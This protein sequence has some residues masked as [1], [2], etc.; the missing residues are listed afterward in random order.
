MTETSLKVLNGILDQQNYRLILYND[1]FNILFISV[2]L[3]LI[4]TLIY[5]KLFS[6][7]KKILS[8]EMFKNVGSSGI[9]LTEIT[10]LFGVV[11]FEDDNGNNK[12]ITCYSY[13][14]KIEKGKRI[15]ITDYDSNKE[16]YIV[17]E[18]PSLG[19]RN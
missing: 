6:N 11:Q 8:N 17:E 19:L 1:M 14:E 7:N 2:I 15:L 18:Y 3:T 10:L 4:I 13:N 5:Y 9:T 12:N 16:M